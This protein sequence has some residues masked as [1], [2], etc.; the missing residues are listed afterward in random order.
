M[1]DSASVGHLVLVGVFAVVV[2]VDRV[3]DAQ[4]KEKSVQDSDEFL[5]SGHSSS[6]FRFFALLSGRGTEQFFFLGGRLFNEEVGNVVQNGIATSSGERHAGI[7]S[8]VFC[9]R[10]G[11][12]RPEAE[13][14]VQVLNNLGSQADVVA[15]HLLVA[16]DA[17]H[18]AD[19]TAQIA[20]HDG[21][22]FRIAELKRYPN[23][24]IFKKV[25][26]SAGNRVDLRGCCSDS[27]RSP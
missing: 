10:V 8:A 7:G 14:G 12:I 1:H 9:R 17:A 26:R 23:E 20:V 22:Q 16:R 21:A 3:N 24:F 27:N 25:K 6:G 11:L 15:H 13:S 5:I 2:I 19:A 4:V 18:S